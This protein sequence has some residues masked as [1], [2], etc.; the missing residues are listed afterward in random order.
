MGSE[1]TIIQRNISNGVEASSGIWMRDYE[2]CL[3][4][5]EIRDVYTEATVLYIILPTIT[6]LW[7]GLDMEPVQLS[8]ILCHPLGGDDMAW[9]CCDG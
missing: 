2:W 4:L 8:T 9:I 6:S 5:M 3:D 7:K 1:G